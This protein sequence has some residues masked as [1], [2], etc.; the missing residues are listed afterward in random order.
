M[1]TLEGFF[2][3]RALTMQLIASTRF[4]D[5]AP[6]ASPIIERSFPEKVAEAIAVIKSLI[7]AGK[8]W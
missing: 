6:V 8:R 2:T 4:Q 7:L 5:A 1:H 3:F